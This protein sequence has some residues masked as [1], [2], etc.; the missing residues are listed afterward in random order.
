MNL[1]IRFIVGH[2]SFHQRMKHLSNR[3]WADPAES[4]SGS[5]SDPGI[6][7]PRSTGQRIR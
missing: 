5:G 2:I 6:L 4:E 3:F 7:P 1:G